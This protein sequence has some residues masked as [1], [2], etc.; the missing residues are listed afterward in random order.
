MRA[1][2]PSSDLR[3][4]C[5]ALASRQDGVI[6]RRQALERGLT[7][8]EISREVRSGRWEIV[9]PG[10]YRIAG[11]PASWKLSLTAA[12][13]WGQGVTFISHR[14]A[15]ALYEMPG[16][17]RGIIEIT[18]S[19]N[20]R[21]HDPDLIIHRGVL[22]AP[23]DRAVFGT[24]PVT[25]PARTLIDLAGVATPEVLEV[26]L[27]DALRR[28]LITLPRL[29]WRIATL[30]VAGRGGGTLIK[31]LLEARASAGPAAESPLETRVIRMLRRSGLPE[32]ARQYEVRS[33][34]KLIGRIDL[35]YP[36]HRLGIEVDGLRYHSGRRQL[37]RDLL[38]RNRLER[39]GWR[40]VHATSEQLKAGPN[41]LIATVRSLLEEA[42]G[43]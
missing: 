14:A 35:A 1:I 2:Q 29:R 23:P 37:E 40:I 30:G 15:G 13:L 42:G 11:A 12:C 6:S 25:S 26:A 22:L 7:A 3:R 43:N 34:G 39:E 16:L 31:N 19:R 41:E 10:V 4:L 24:L 32:P 9:F 20:L 18:T 21:S 36:R 5:A 33:G 17:P 28:R 38:R 8:S 27:D